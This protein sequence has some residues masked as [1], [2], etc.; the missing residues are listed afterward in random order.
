MMSNS[1]AP[2][3]A[4]GDE[5][6][7]H[8]RFHTS[9]HVDYLHGEHFLFSYIQN[10]S[11]MGIFIH[12]ESPLPIGT[13]LKLR[14]SPPDKDLLELEGEV[15]WVNPIRAS[16]DNPN[17]GMGVRFKNLDADSRE[18]IVELIRTVAYLSQDMEPV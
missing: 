5:R 1:Q 7:R 4:G 16:G 15:V 9:L 10:I 3:S 14:F 13:V 17:P 11:V 12:S 18:S 8:E 2:D 6:R